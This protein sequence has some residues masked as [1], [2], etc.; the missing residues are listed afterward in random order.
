MVAPKSAADGPD[1]M[2]SDNRLPAAPVL[3][4]VGLA[5][6]VALIAGVLE[7]VIRLVIVAGVFDRQVWGDAKLV[8]LAPLAYLLILALPTG[9]MALWAARDRGRNSWRGSLGV[10]LFVGILGLLL[11]EPSLHPA[12]MAV[13]AAGAAVQGTRLLHPRTA[14][15]ER[16]IRRG[17][18]WLAGAVIAFGLT[19]AGGQRLAEIREYRR[20]PK[21]T[22]SSPNVLMIIWDTV[23]GAS[24]SLYGYERPTTPGLEA[25]ARQS[26]VFDHAWSTAPWTLPSH[27]SLLTGRLPQ[28]LA[29]GPR[30]PIREGFATLTETLA[31]NGFLTAGFVANSRYAGR[32]YGVGRGFLHFEDYVVTPGL[33][34]A[35]A[36]PIRAILRSHWVRH[37]IGFWEKLDLVRAPRINRA[38]LRWLDRQAP[39]RPYFALLNYFDAHDPYL[40]P[41]PF[42]TL[43]GADPTRDAADEYGWYGITLTPAQARLEQASYDAA[44]RYLDHS[45]RSL[46]ETLDRRGALDNT[47]VIITADHGEQFGEHGRLYHS[48]SLY[49]ELLWVPLLLRFPGRVPAGRRVA[50]HVSLRDVPA[51]VLDLI[52]IPEPHPL[53]GA[54]LRAAWEDSTAAVWRQPILAGTTDEHRRTSHAVIWENGY[55]VDW[56]ETQEEFYDWLV[57]RGLRRNLLA[58]PSSAKLPEFYRVTRDSLRRMAAARQWR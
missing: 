44:I 3:L 57:D 5:A 25:T 42:D 38:F 47:L 31:A 43:F 24:L 9:V 16:V 18:P 11:L 20:L 37:A 46:L 40:P 55:H 12:A 58:D 41:A 27:G 33:F 22:T 56:Q 50:T 23:R 52:G 53:P 51:T 6:S 4:I 15:V 30:D 32:R 35:S 36:S 17:L 26:V 48:N 54:T 13:I 29:A 49:R 19:V 39:D 45:T 10:S 34:F 14:A 21:S 2:R 8:W 1:Q 7:A 28:E